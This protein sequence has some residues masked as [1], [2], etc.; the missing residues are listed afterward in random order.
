MP[1]PFGAA[2]V[3]LEVSE[4][5]PIEAP[6]G[7][8]LV[9][10]LRV[11][12]TAGRNRCGMLAHAIGPDGSETSHALTAHDGTVSETGDILLRA[13][14]LL[15][16]H[17]W[18]FSLPAHEMAGVCYPE[19]TLAVPVR[20]RPQT[21]SLA[22]WAVP[23]PVVTGEQ[24]KVRVGAKSSADCELKGR[25]VE[26]RHNGATVA[27]GVLGDTPWPGTALS[28]TELTLIAPAEP[29][30]CSWSVQFEATELEVPHVGTSSVF[31]VAV[32]RSPDHTL[33]IK[34]VE[35]G[36]AAP[37]EDA[38]VRLGAYRAETGRS[39]L[40]EIRM[41][42]GRYELQ[43]WKAGY[44]IKPATLD[45]DDDLSIEVEALAVLEEDPDARWKM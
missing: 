40:A 17:V 43:V 28:W 35:Q 12:C 38:T 2:L 32:V 26:I 16:E 23:S 27:R 18:R 10:R 19:V 29:G 3:H 1:T 6:A 42:K 30:L 13:P 33:I 34:V 44:D 15:G 5:V 31:S 22:V 21:T 20:V 25:S 41:P 24:F 14:L 37:I 11:S 45:L 36:S 7:G 39:G 4:P 9:I 8:A